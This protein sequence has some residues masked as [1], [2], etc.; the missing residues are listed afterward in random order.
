MN[1]LS[2]TTSGRRKLIIPMWQK[3]VQS[4]TTEAKKIRS[5]SHLVRILNINRIVHYKIS[6]IRKGEQQRKNNSNAVFTSLIWCDVAV[7][8]I[9]QNCIRIIKYWWW[10]ND[11]GKR[12][13]RIWMGRR[14]VVENMQRVIRVISFIKFIGFCVL[15]QPICFCGASF[16]SSFVFA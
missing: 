1:F 4:K 8:S 15:S 13:M 10:R 12:P 5:F 7:V 2:T 3:S 11:A 6:W 9:F 14:N 16:A